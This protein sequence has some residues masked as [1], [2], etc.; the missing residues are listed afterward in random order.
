MNVLLKKLQL[1][2]VKKSQVIYKQGEESTNFYIVLTG[3]V[4]VLTCVSVGRKSVNSSNLGTH[5]GTVQMRHLVR[6]LS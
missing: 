3:K 5:G 4:S 6:Q 2:P 1:V